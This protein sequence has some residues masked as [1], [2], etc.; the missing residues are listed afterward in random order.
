MEKEQVRQVRAITDFGR[1]DMLSKNDVMVSRRDIKIEDDFEDA[2]DAYL[3]NVKDVDLYSVIFI[4]QEEEDSEMLAFEFHKEAIKELVYEFVEGMDVYN[5]SIVF[6]QTIGSVQLRD[7]LVRTSSPFR[8]RFDF[9]PIGVYEFDGARASAPSQTLIS[10]S[11][12]EMPGMKFPPIRVL[13]QYDRI[14]N[15]PESNVKQHKL[16]GFTTTILTLTHL[17]AK[18]LI[19]G[20]E[21][22]DGQQ[23][24]PES[25]ES[26]DE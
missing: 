16:I 1:V 22:H 20:E 26:K 23:E 19:G 18:Y 21:A 6:Y 4:F 17:R 2:L 14:E 13:H 10:A 15:G 25:A 3:L 12:E 11:G 24:S 5:F 7:M 8:V 9:G